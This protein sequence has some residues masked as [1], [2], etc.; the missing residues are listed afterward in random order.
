MATIEEA[1]YG[2]ITSD[3]GV[4]ATGLAVFA[5]EATQDTQPPYCTISFIAVDDQMVSYDLSNSNTVIRTYQ[6]SVIT[7]GVI[8]AETIINALRAAV[9]GS[10]RDTTGV[11]QSATPGAESR[12]KNDDLQM[13]Y[14]T[15]DIRLV[16]QRS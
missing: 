3:A 1:L 6:L 4:Q 15:I 2:L 12:H 11:I 14:R 10:G 9:L 8:Q 7:R 5:D 13:F 16:G